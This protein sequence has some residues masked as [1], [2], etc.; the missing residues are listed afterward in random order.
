MTLTDIHVSMI[1]DVP[2]DDKEALKCYCLTQFYHFSIKSLLLFFFSFKKYF[3]FS[4]LIIKYDTV[5]QMYS[6]KGTCFYLPPWSRRGLAAAWEALQASR[7][8]NLSSPT[9]APPVPSPVMT[10]LCFL[11]VLFS[12]SLS[13]FVTVCLPL[14]D[15]AV[16]GARHTFSSESRHPEASQQV[17]SVRT[18]SPLRALL[19]DSHCSFKS[20]FL[21]GFLCSFFLLAFSSASLLQTRLFSPL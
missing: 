1:S 11:I 16:S 10:S 2:E 4:L 14:R 17:L 7:H 13:L 20:F 18:C 15:L 8:H 19:L 21:E 9:K 12:E 6:E 5:T 3:H